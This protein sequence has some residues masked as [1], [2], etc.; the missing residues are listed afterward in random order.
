MNEGHL[1]SA[2]RYVALNPARAHLVAR[3]EDWKWSSVRAHLEGKDDGLVAVMPVLDRVKDF[4][5]LIADRALQ[6]LDEIG[7]SNGSARVLLQP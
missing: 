4:A 1:I 7:A 6:A 5:A 2:V 3:T